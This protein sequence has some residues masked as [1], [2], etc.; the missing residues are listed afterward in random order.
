LGGGHANLQLGVLEAER[1]LA[2]SAVLELLA[3]SRLDLV[4]LDGAVG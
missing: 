4:E 2:P 3:V 1:S